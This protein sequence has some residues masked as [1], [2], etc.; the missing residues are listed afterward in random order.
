[1]V[2]F[3]F[4][5]SPKGKYFV[6]RSEFPVDTDFYLRFVWPTLLL[7]SKPTRF[8]LGKCTRAFFRMVFRDQ[9]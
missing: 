7:A 2:S 6:G 1:M 8:L 3:A 9:F 4:V 5:A